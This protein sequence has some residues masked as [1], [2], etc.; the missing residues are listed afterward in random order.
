MAVS[1]LIPRESIGIHNV[2]RNRSKSLEGTLPYDWRI[3][4]DFRT[5]ARVALW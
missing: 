2:G 1:R 5:E 3:G 4:G